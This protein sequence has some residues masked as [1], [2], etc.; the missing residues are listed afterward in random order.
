M[1]RF[2]HIALI[3]LLATF[4]LLAQTGYAH[5][6]N[7]ST[8]PY[9]NSTHRYQVTMGNSANTVGWKLYKGTIANAA[10]PPTDGTSYMLTP[11]GTQTWAVPAV[12]GSN[13]Y[14]DITFADNVFA[15]ADGTWTLIYSEYSVVNGN[16]VAIRTMQITPEANT[17][18]LTLSADAS[19]CHPLNGE[20]LN[21]D[22]INNTPV[23]APQ[24]YTVTMHKSDLFHTK[25]WEFTAT[26][27][28]DGPSG[29]TYSG[30]GK[31]AYTGTSSAG[32]SYTVTYTAT[33]VKVVVV[34]TTNNTS[35]ETV[36][37]PVP[38]SGLVYKGVD[39]T[40]SL[41]EGVARSGT[42]YEVVTNDNLKLPAVPPDRSQTITLLPLPATS[43]IAI[44]D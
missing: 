29:Y 27:S 1:N 12:D 33:T 22:A 5:A 32:N 31:E 21:W 9:F 43:N 6:Q 30:A 25:S 10:T 36:S 17:F 20:V 42:T 35:E 23:E 18:Y 39:A 40:I 3:L 44:V 13:A 19:D 34:T 7:S 11:S 41:T 15:A 8:A 4:A 14:V 16:C 38:I 28:F 26:P 37:F 2:R 24:T